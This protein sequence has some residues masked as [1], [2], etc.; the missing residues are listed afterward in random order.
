MPNIQ[1]K[2]SPER[3]EDDLQ[4][5]HERAAD[6]ALSLI[7]GAIGAI[8]IAGSVAAEVFGL[9]LGPPIVRRR[10]QWMEL[11]A[12]RLKALEESDGIPL[13]QLAEN[14]TFLDTVLQATQAASKTQ[15]EKKREALKNAVLNSARRGAPD[16][17]T[18]HMFLDFVDRFTE[19]HLLL[20]ELFHGPRGWAEEHGRQLP[21][22]LMMGA[23]AHILEAVYPELAT[24]QEFYRQVWRDLDTAGLVSGDSLAGTMTYQGMIA[25]RTT[26]FGDRFLAFI[27]A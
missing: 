12:E 1:M 19:W 26:E 18:Q 23:P 25:K 8:P 15:S 2:R 21:T 16:A 24:R 7:K 11:V 4:V 27:K 6:K 20:L 17:A 14:G 9:V 5:P 10:D 3:S 22:D 13:T